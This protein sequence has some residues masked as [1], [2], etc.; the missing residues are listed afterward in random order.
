MAC[1][2]SSRRGMAIARHQREEQR[3]AFVAEVRDSLPRVPLG[4]PTAWQAN[5]RSIEH[6]REGLP[7]ARGMADGPQRPHAAMV[8][9]PC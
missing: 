9:K 8:V 5:A 7:I 2:R 4:A 1:S 3:G 6:A